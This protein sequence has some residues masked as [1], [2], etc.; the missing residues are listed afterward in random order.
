MG[1]IKK[2]YNSK[3]WKGVRKFTGDRYGRFNRKSS[4]FGYNIPK[5]VSDVKTLGDMINAE[6]KRIEVVSGLY[7]VAQNY[8]VTGS[9]HN[10][11]DITPVVPQGI[12]YNTRNGSSI[13]LHSTVMKFNMVQQSQQNTDLRVKIYIFRTKGIPTAFNIANLLDVNPFNNR[14]DFNS[15]RNIDKMPQFQILSI[16]N[17]TIKGDTVGSQTNQKDFMIAWKHKGDSHIRYDKDTFTVTKGQIYMVMVANNGDYGTPQ[18]GV[19]IQHT[20]K[21]FYYDN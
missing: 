6:K 21:H 1:I 11:T 12:T 15:S 16:R 17:I 18:S 2:A 19:Q 4:T 20:L 5:I 9:G 7:Y 14:Y 10:V 13:K 8:N 3:T